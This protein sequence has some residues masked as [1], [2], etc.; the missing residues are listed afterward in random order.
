MAT[1]YPTSPLGWFEMPA[2]AL[3]PLLKT[4]RLAN[5]AFDTLFYDVAKV[6]GELAERG[7]V[8]TVA[9]NAPA[10]DPT[11]LGRSL[12]QIDLGALSNPEGRIIVVDSRTPPYLTEFTDVR[13]FLEAE[14]GPTGKVD[15]VS[16]TGVGSSALGSV[17][18]AWNVS[19]ALDGPVAAIVPGY[20]VADV[21]E[22][23]MGGWL[24][25]GLYGQQV[26]STAQNV[27]ADTA[28]ATATVGRHLM[29]SV[30]GHEETVTE[31][32]LSDWIT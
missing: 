15:T 9:G 27:L 26:K 32:E 31:R 25:F 11:P 8:I 21:I 20:G 10:S 29:M 4:L 13:H 7:I 18:F 12:R 1:P 6:A 24:G 19:V 14:S 5:T 2:W 17:A 23:A 30:P 22:Q 16:I 28:P 3:E